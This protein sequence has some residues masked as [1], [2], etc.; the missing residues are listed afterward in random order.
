MIL[1]R[2][3]ALVA[4]LLLVAASC[5]SSSPRSGRTSTGLQSDGPTPPARPSPSPQNLMV[6][7]TLDFDS[8]T[9][10]GEILATI[11]YGEGA[12]EL[13]FVPV[14]TRNCSPPCPCTTPFQPS[15]FDID[16]RDRVWILDN[17][18]RRVA[19]FRAPSDF[20]F[21][22]PGNNRLLLIAA[23]L[24]WVGDQ[25]VA[26]SQNPRFESKLLAIQQATE[27]RRS[28][29]VFEGEPA[30][31]THLWTDDSRMF[32]TVFR[33][34][35]LSDEEVPVEVTLN[36][37]GDSAAEE[38]P[39]RPFLDGWLLFQDYVG[40]RIIPLAVS[41]AEHNWRLEIRLRLQ[42][43][44]EGEKKSRA[45]NVSWES[46]VDPAGTIHLLVFAGTQGRHAAD[47]YWYLQVSP[48]GAV[49]DPLHLKG[50][51]RRDDQQL[52]RLT[53]DAGSRPVVMWAGRKSARLEILTF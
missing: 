27:I 34:E 23:D 1:P 5:P 35:G 36:E 42:Q 40:P 53:L 39:G 10:S 7:R 24:Q 16:S 13:G 48:D 4:G 29:I 46:E 52:R 37:S 21:D 25:A 28:S 49:G 15:A 43:T 47:D 38:V 12:Q 6:R 45:G 19:V 32:T 20:L 50:P 9:V 51:S 18:K 11:P 41:S 14:C 33:E 17:A 30:E 8:P 22:V 31:T 44:I 3:T 26:L 2:A